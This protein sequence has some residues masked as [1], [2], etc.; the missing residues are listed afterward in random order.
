MSEPLRFRRKAKEIQVSRQEFLNTRPLR[1]P[2][3]KWESNENGKVT[4][5]IPYKKSRFANIFSRI[6]K[7]KQVV[8]DKVGSQVWNFCDGNHT[9]ERIAESIHQEYK[10]TMEEAEAA[11]RTYFNQ[12]SERGIVGFM[13]HQQNKGSLSKKDKRRKSNA[14][15]ANL[16]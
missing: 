2:R 6:P 3:L 9:I 13:L 8:L 10:L 11:L 5:F 7:E 1:N 4:V 15:R 16:A 12:L 14:R